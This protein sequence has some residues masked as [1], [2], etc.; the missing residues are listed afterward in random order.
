MV[1]VARVEAPAIRLVSDR[2]VYIGATGSGKSEL[3]RAHFE[4]ARCR[5][6]L[7]D[8]KHSWKVAG[9]KACYEVREIDWQAPVIHFRPRWAD[10]DQSDELYRAAFERLRHAYVWTD[11]A[12]GVSDSNWHGSALAAVQTQG[13][14]LELGHGLCVQRPVNVRREIVT[15]A[16]HAFL[17][18][19]IDDEDLKVCRQGC[20]FLPLEQ[21]RE[22][23]YGLA[24][25]EYLWINKPRKTVQ[26][27]PALPDFLRQ[28]KLVHRRSNR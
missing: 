28:P 3:A 18:G 16:T 26:V 24:E 23:V 10:R 7:V 21:L 15:E 11:E 5:R 17:F 9:V 25:H 4:S 22:L 14:E 20:T 19:Q 2:L 27:G 6:M 13:R 12:Y 1:T 8:P